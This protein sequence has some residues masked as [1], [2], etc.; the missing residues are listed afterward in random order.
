MK[1]AKPPKFTP[2]ELELIRLVCTQVAH[3]TRFGKQR[4]QLWAIAQKAGAVL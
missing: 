1:A 3:K 4:N 2:A